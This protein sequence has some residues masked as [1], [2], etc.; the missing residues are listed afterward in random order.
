MVVTKP[1]RPWIVQKYGG[2]SLGKMLDRICEEIIPTSL[3]TGRLVIACSALSSSE[4][5]NGTTTLLLDCIELA[6]KPEE[7]TASAQ[8]ATNLATIRDNHFQIL[9]QDT[10]D[11]DRSGLAEIEAEIIDDCSE[12]QGILKAAQA[13]VPLFKSCVS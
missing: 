4:K 13:Y 5:T 3:E 2:T 9:Q 8:I 10:R 6:Q 7:S 12:A 1:Q 11:F